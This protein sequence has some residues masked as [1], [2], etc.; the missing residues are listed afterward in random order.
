MHSYARVRLG[1]SYDKRQASFSHPACIFWSSRPVPIFKLTRRACLESSASALAFSTLSFTMKQASMFSTARAFFEA[2]HP[3]LCSRQHTAHAYP[4]F[5]PRSTPCTGRQQCHPCAPAP[6]PARGPRGPGGGGPP[7][8][9][10]PG[11]AVRRLPRYLRVR[12]TQQTLLCRR[13]LVHMRTCAAQQL[14]VFGLS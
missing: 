10:A 11:A 4:F 8:G 13:K 2:S 12:I 1:F 3:Y 9:A 5:V 6:A 7:A 14:I